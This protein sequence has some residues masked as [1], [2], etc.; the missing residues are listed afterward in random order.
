MANV[1]QTRG[2]LGDGTLLAQCGGTD[3]V[4]AGVAFFEGK[5]LR[6]GDDIWIKGSDR[7]I[8]GSK[9][10][11]MDDAG[12]RIDAPDKPDHTGKLVMF[13]V[14]QSLIK[15]RTT[16]GFPITINPDKR[17]KDAVAVVEVEGETIPGRTFNG[18]P[19]A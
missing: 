13:K 19:P 17:F 15:P 5:G 4:V 10:I 14:R 9:A 3:P 8:G 12:P 11:C 6:N 7:E 16:L 1:A 2:R 18:D